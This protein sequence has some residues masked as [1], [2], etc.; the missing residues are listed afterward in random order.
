VWEPLESNNAERF[1]RVLH[2]GTL[3]RG[4]DWMPL[5]DFIKLLESNVPSDLAD[6]CRYM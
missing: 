4:M 6:A 1:V 5:S 2:E 3:V